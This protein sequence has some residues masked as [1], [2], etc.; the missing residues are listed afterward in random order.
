MK[1]DELSLIKIV[2]LLKSDLDSEIINSGKKWTF[3]I[4]TLLSEPG[5]LYVCK[6]KLNLIFL[7]MPLNIKFCTNKCKSG[8]Q[9]LIMLA[10]FRHIVFKHN[11]DFENI[12]W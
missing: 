8:V 12:S 2:L 6:S 4:K 9:T 11:V 10:D 1:Q 3:E 7:F 5:F